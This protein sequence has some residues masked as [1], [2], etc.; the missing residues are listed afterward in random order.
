MLPKTINNTAYSIKEFLIVLGVILLSKSLYYESYGNNVLLIVFFI[1]LFFIAKVRVRFLSFTVRVRARDIGVDNKLIL[2]SLFFMGLVLINPESKLSTILVLMARL[3]IAYIV[4]SRL[5]FY[6]FSTIFIKI[7]LILSFFSLFSLA[8]FHFNI[9][10]FLPDFVAIDHRQL[11][12]FLFFAADNHNLEYRIWGG[13]YRIT[14]L[15][16]EPGAFQLFV[17]LAVIFAIINQSLTKKQ[18]ILFAVTIM[19][20]KSTTGMIVFILLSLIIVNKLLNIHVNAKYLRYFFVAIVIM[21][22]SWYA[23]PLMDKF[24]PESQYFASFLSRYNDVVVSYHLLLDNFFLGYGYGH[25]EKIIPYAVKYA[26]VGDAVRVSGADGITMLIAQ[27][28]ILGIFFLWHFFI[29]NYYKHLTLLE[30]IVISL[31]LLLMFNTE[32]FTF[33]LIFIILIFYGIVGNK[34]PT[35]Q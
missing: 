29:P 23:Y 30:K 6:I 22:M 28:G 15:W 24:H 25:L 17:N 11:R 2:Y 3:A 9:P 33:I 5:N 7:V 26:S 18:Y 14:G 10:S 35:Y 16:W 27:T 20:I 34:E 31:S 19:L 8:V 32:N 13:V 21:A 1:L 12:N 4:V